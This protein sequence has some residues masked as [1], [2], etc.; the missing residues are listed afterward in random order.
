MDCNVKEIPLTGRPSFS[1]EYGRTKTD[2]RTG[3]PVNESKYCI[4][5]SPRCQLLILTLTNVSLVSTTFSSSSSVRTDL[6]FQGRLPL[7]TGKLDVGGVPD[8][9]AWAGRP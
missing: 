1:N 3:L 6:V 8:G 2:T 4:S 9:L 7:V 5:F